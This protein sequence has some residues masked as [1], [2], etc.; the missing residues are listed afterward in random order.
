MEGVTSSSKYLY[1]VKWWPPF[2]SGGLI[3]L[4]AS[5]DKECTTLLERRYPEETEKYHS[6]FV[7]A[8][9]DAK[10]LE[11]APPTLGLPPLDSE[12]IE[13]VIG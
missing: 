2:G 4:V 5:N 6:A 9:F 10:K 13:A 3:A 12:I 7:V 8:L 1:L 11:L